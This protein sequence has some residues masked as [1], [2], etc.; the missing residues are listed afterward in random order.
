ML[1]RRL[2]IAHAMAIAAAGLA[3]IG[4]VGGAVEVTPARNSGY[5]MGRRS[6]PQPDKGGY[7]GAKLAKQARKGTLTICRIR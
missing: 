1:E 5:R 6:M 3:S 4:S 2:G 7:P